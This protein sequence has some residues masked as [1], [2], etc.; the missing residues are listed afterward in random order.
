MAQVG[1]TPPGLLALGAGFADP[2]IVPKLGTKADYAF[3]RA[4]WAPD[5]GRKNS[6]AAAVSD[7]FSARFGQPMTEGAAHE[8]EAVM[9]LGAAL[10]RAD[11]TDPTSLQKALNGLDITRTI[12]SWAGIKF[13]GTGQNALASGVV[14]QLTGGQYHIVYPPEVASAKPVWPAPAFDKR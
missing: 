10:E 4:A 9:T 12:T 7:T 5:V 8:F 11:T 13:D 1:Y 2:Q 6:T 14:E 3:D